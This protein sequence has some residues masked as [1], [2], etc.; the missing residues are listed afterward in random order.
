MNVTDAAFKEWCRLLVSGWINV[1][2]R[3]IIL[4]HN[5]QAQHGFNRE[6]VPGGV[7]RVVIG[8]RKGPKLKLNIFKREGDFGTFNAIQEEFDSGTV[9]NDGHGMQ[10]AIVIGSTIESGHVISATGGH[11]SILTDFAIVAPA[12][13][14]THIGKEHVAGLG[15]IKNPKG[16]T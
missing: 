6:I 9:G 11:I 5:R 12:A 13:L 7:G 16:T 10:P 14:S 2:G 8:A 1:I 3:K 15:F 4:K